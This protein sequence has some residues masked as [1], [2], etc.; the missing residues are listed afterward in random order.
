MVFTTRYSQ[1]QLKDI[2]VSANQDFFLTPA[3]TPG[4]DYQVLWCHLPGCT[5]AGRRRRCKVDVLL[6]N[7]RNLTIPVVPPSSMEFSRTP[8]LPI[9]PL[10]PLLLVKLQGWLARREGEKEA[11]DAQD[12]YLLLQLAM[13]RQLFVWDDSMHWIPISFISE[14]QP[15][16][17]EFV[18]EYPK[19]E[20]AWRMIGFAVRHKEK[21][22]DSDI[23]S[24]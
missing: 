24:V 15:W 8:A 1:E 11:V 13:G 3:A 7:N 9:M 21:P 2:L 19:T 22:D 16:I 18:D 23:D 6:P 4:A 14:A 10:I 5:R 20:K 17:E 12:V